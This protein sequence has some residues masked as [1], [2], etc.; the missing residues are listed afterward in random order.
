MDIPGNYD[1]TIL[2]DHY[3]YNCTNFD[4]VVYHNAEPVFMQFGPYESQESDTFQ[5]RVWTQQVNSA[6]G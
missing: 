6:T 2:K 3:L 1:F 4:D 5:S